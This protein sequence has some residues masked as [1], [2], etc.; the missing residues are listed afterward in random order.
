MPLIFLSIFIAG[1]ALEYGVERWVARM[2]GAAV[3]SKRWMWLAPLFAFG[4][5]FFYLWCVKIQ[6]ISLLKEP[7]DDIWMRFFVHALLFMLL[8]AATLIDFDEM[9]IPDE[10]TIQGTIC[11]LFFAAALPNSLLPALHWLG[12]SE[13]GYDIFAENSVP[14]LWN[15]PFSD[16]QTPRQ[17]WQ[18]LLG[19]FLWNFWCFANMD[20]C[21]HPKLGCRKAA[22]L[23]ARR[24]KKCRTTIPLC[25]LG[26]LGTLIIVCFYGFLPPLNWNT[27]LSSII[28]LSTGGAIIWGTRFVGSAALRQQAMGFG[29]VTLM[30]MIGAFLGWQPCIVIFFLAPI[31][32]LLIGIAR[33]ILGYG[34]AMPYGP[35]LCAAALYVVVFWRSVWEFLEPFLL[36]GWLLPVGM[37][38]CILLL[39]AM[40]YAWMRIKAICF[41]GFAK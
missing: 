34:N 16:G 29:D 20:R 8:W 38:L 26:F 36:L 41:N 37:A 32:G 30:C 4:L 40:L 35:F 2:K 9:I 10:I 11:G 13:H 15:S 22:A 1:F 28:G 24:L 3:P 6:G 39:G 7:S 25:L 21:W 17:I 18:L 12:F 31:A 19:V 27:F 14:L 23:F 33:L 5:C